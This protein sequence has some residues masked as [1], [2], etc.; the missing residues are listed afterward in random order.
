MRDAIVALAP[1]HH[2]I[3]VAPGIRTRAVAEDALGPAATTKTGTGQPA[4]HRPV[5]ETELLLRAIYPDG[6][7]GRSVLDCACNAGGHLFGAARAGAGSGLGFDAREH[8][9]AQARFLAQHLPATALEFE[10]LDLYDL[11]SQDR[12]QFDVCFFNGIFYHLP[13]PVAGLRIAAD[14][15]REML[16]VNTA[17]TSGPGRVLVLNQE[18]DEDPVSG[19]HRLAWLPTPDVLLPILEWCGMPHA[20]VVWEAAQAKH[21]PRGRGRIIVA[22]ARRASALEKLESARRTRPRTRAPRTTRRWLRR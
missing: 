20:R 2:D 19:V 13:D 8:W 14:H 18:S 4:A 3:E 5:E 17:T 6:L 15:T 21:G 9:I 12:G 10:V 7:E 22:A 11:P 1:W 16:I